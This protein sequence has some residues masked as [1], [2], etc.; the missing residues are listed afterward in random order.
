MFPF[1]SALSALS[2]VLS[3][4]ETLTKLETLA[5]QNDVA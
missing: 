5:Q 1:A 2:D 4:E 3:L